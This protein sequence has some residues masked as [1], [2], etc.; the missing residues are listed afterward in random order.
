M[1]KR[2][3][4]TTGLIIFLLLGALAMAMGTEPHAPKPLAPTEAPA[5]GT[6][7]GTIVAMKGETVIVETEE[8][9]TV[10]FLVTSATKRDRRFQVG[11]RIE[12]AMSPQ[13]I[14]TTMQL[15]KKE[16]ALRR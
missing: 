5:G 2:A 13:G 6:V 9:R 11:D 16:K 4:I 8:G 12:A 14:A 15:L 1:T 10:R 7:E 3:W